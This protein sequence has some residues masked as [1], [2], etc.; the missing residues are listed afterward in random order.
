MQPSEPPRFSRGIGTL[1]AA[2]SLQEC[3]NYFDVQAT[4]QRHRNPL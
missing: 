4:L 2:F 1:T 3:A